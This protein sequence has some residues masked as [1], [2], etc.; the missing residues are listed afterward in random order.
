MACLNGSNSSSPCSDV[1]PNA[2]VL[3]L[4]T[5]SGAATIVGHAAH[6]K[7]HLALVAELAG[8]VEQID[9]DLLQPQAV[10]GVHIGQLCRDLLGDDQPLGLRPVDDEGTA[11]GGELTQR[12]GRGL[13][14]HGTGLALGEVEDVVDECEQ[15][16]AAVADDLG[17]LTLLGLEGVVE[18]Q[19][20]QA[21]DRVHRGAQLVADARKE[22]VA[23]LH[24]QLG[25][26]LLLFELGGL[27]PQALQRALGEQARERDERAVGQQE[28][29][30]D[31]E[32][33]DVLRPGDEH[34]GEQRDRDEGDQCQG[35]PSAEV[36][37]AQQQ[38][39]RQPDQ[40]EQHLGWRGAVRQLAQ[41][42]HDQREHRHAGHR[43]AG[44]PGSP[45]GAGDDVAHQQEHDHTRQV[46]EAG[47]L[48]ERQVQPG[49]DQQHA[50]EARQQHDAVA[51]AGVGA[52]GGMGLEEDLE[53]PPPPPSGRVTP[54]EGLV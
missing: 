16:L 8:V 54:E 23:G 27:V 51:Q 6:A 5:Q 47:R 42:E 28:R 26:H 46:V 24:C 49:E 48:R 45:P 13:Q 2:P 10:A 33:D 44:D 12:E 7:L 52:H 30:P 43:R 19:A 17:P 3:H 37:A 11:V 21:D 41:A 53:E 9:Q 34:V 40:P 4:E 29:E 35:H 36:H 50:L 1:K 20:R 14:C 15:R 18:Q 22:P 32:C 31:H 25:P 38:G 39:H